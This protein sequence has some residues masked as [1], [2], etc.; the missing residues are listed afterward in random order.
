MTIKANGI[1]LGFLEPIILKM[2][3]DFIAT[4]ANL[5]INLLVGPE[6]FKTTEIA[7]QVLAHVKLDPTPAN[8]WSVRV[9][10]APIVGGQPQ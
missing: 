2:W 5:P 6:L 4:S 10:F 1:D 3:T 8:P 9:Q 7:K